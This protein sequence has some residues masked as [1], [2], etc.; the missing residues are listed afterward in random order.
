MAS[1]PFTIFL[2][3]A[4][5][6]VVVIFV[7]IPARPIQESLPSQ[8]PT[9]RR[10]SKV[11]YYL[12]PGAFDIKRG[13]PLR[14]WF[15]FTTFAFSTLAVFMCWL[16]GLPASAPGI[17]TG[18]S[19]PN[20]FHAFPWPHTPALEAGVDSWE[21]FHWDIFWSWYGA[22]VFWSVV[23]LSALLSLSL[24]VARFRKIWKL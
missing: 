1:L 7:L 2:F 8:G 6:A 17:V 14:G 22:K 20:I 19:V 13:S 4:V 23:A 9:K 24:H 15:A 10:F 16:Y 21:Y 18:W 12:I 5:V 11:V 3:F